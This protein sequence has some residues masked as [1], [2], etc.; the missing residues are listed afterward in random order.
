MG[1]LLPVEYSLKFVRKRV[2]EFRMSDVD[3]SLRPLHNGLSE[4]ICDPILRHDEVDIR[5]V[6]DDRCPLLDV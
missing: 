2:S 5:S 1:S 6:R 3:Q 4:K